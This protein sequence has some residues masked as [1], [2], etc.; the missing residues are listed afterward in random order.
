MTRPLSCF[1]EA[2]IDGQSFDKSFRVRRA[3]INAHSRS[4]LFFEED[5]RVFL[6]LDSQRHALRG[7]TAVKSQ[8]RRKKRRSLFLPR[9]SHHIE[10]PSRLL[11]AQFRSLNAPL[12]LTFYVPRSSSSS[13]S[14]PA[15]KSNR[16]PAER[17]LAIAGNGN[18]RNY[19]AT[20]IL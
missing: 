15:E 20:R 13:S 12:L 3:K 4:G 8:S 19:G 16:G 14:R 1:K 9:Y 6:P 10:T 18:D 2:D 5:V 17:R 7:L 11:L